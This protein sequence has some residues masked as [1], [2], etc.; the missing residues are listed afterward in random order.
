MS[1]LLSAA[2]SEL[3]IPKLASLSELRDMCMQVLRVTNPTQ[4]GYTYEELKALDD[5]SVT[6]MPEK[7]GM[8]FKHVEYLVES[9]VRIQMEKMAV[10]SHVSHYSD[11]QVI[12]QEA[13]QRF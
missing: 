1:T 8:V 4:L 3:P 7:K 5:I 6:I 11:A 13:L 9:K 2:S 12:Y 10:G